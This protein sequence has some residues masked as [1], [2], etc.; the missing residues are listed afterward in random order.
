MSRLAFVFLLTPFA[1]T[2][3][4]DDGAVQRALIQRDQQSAEFAAGAR[5]SVMEALHERQLLEA[6][7]E[8]QPGQ[9]E[10]MARER[11]GL[12]LQQAAPAAPAPIS[13]APLPL[14]GGPAHGVQPIPA[15]RF[16]G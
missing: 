1:W 10:R 6:T 9:R 7:A 13:N 8:P 12:L 14:P 5:R 15:H 11:E 2:A 16:G 4:A 3:Q